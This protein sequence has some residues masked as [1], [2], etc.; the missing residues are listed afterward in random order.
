MK[1]LI[2]Q[3]LREYTEPKVSI[4][5]LGWYNGNIPDTII[6]ENYNWKVN[7]EGS[8]QSWNFLINYL[9]KSP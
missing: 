9:G 3:I 2:R 8:E 4:R 6:N 5:V 7:P 1:D